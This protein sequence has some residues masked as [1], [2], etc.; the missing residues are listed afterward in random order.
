MFSAYQQ[1]THPH[2]PRFSVSKGSLKACSLHYIMMRTNERRWSREDDESWEWMNREWTW[3]WH[4]FGI[5]VIKTTNGDLRWMIKAD[6]FSVPNPTIRARIMNSQEYP[7]KITFDLIFPISP[8]TIDVQLTGLPSHIGIKK[9]CIDRRGNITCPGS[10]SSCVS[11]VYR[12]SLSLFG[13]LSRFMNRFQTMLDFKFGPQVQQVIY[14][15][16][17]TG[18]NRLRINLLRVHWLRIISLR[19]RMFCC[20]AIRSCTVQTKETEERT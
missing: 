20:K 14:L 5:R 19:T 18:I 12:C 7:R 9:L 10:I 17:T 6:C 11:K 15:L 16:C 4:S 2:S 1:E 3:S 8:R 13:L